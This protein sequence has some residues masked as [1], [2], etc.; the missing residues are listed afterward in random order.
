MDLNVNGEP[1]H[2][3]DGHTVA[4]LVVDLGLGG[5]AVAV[6]VNRNV[7]PKRLHA[8]TTLNEGDAIEIVTLV[9]G[10]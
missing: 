10:G 6:E 4:D 9:G 2:L 3:P 1:K 5:R 7:V 8:S